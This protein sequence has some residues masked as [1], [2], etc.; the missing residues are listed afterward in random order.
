M[1]K[2]D[3]KRP[4]GAGAGGQR[5]KNE[6]GGLGGGVLAPVTDQTQTAAALPASGL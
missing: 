3:L 2:Q 6:E 1:C 5:V 4:N